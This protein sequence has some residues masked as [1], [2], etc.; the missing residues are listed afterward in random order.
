LKGPAFFA[1]HINHAEFQSFI[2]P[3]NV[4]GQ[5]L[6]SHLVAIT[7]LITPIKPNERA[8]RKTSHF[9][10]GMVRWLE[11]AHANIDPSMRSYI[12]WPIKRADEVREWLQYEGALAA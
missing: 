1:C 7:T 5:L 3:S 9:A 11:V 6:L 10:N 4:V 2:N 8:G 12:E